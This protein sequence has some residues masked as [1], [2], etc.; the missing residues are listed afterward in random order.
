MK[1]STKTAFAVVFVIGIAAAFWLI[2]LGPK[3][4]KAS[5]LGDQVTRIQSEVST[6]Q[7]RAESSLAAKASYSRDYAQLVGLGKAV[8]TEAATP[9]LLVQIQ[10]LSTASKTDFN[11]ISGAGGEEGTP[12]S[13]VPTEGA[14]QLAPLGATP[15][16]AGL[17][18]MPY[19]FEFEGGFFD[20][21]NFIEGLDSL[22]TTTDAGLEADGRLDR[23]RLQLARPA[24]GPEEAASSQLTAASTSR[25]T[26]PRPV[27]VSTPAAPAKNRS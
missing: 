22:V 3:R 25:P 7:A 16:P 4:D 20:I 6:E 18:K 15:G 9:S 26:S 23:R 13:P 21:A 8:P 27:R 19:T 10:G 2:L 14:T 17:L 24:K 5:E 12:E 11:G 1:E